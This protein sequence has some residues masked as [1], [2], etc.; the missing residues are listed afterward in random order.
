MVDEAISSLR[1][2]DSCVAEPTPR[3]MEDAKT[4]LAYLIEAIGP[5]R[6]YVPEVSATLDELTRWFS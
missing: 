3:K 1:F 6:G 2:I 4:R 5:Y